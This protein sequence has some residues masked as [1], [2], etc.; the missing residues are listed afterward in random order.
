MAL[1]LG[2]FDDLIPCEEYN[3]IYPEESEFWAWVDSMERDFVNKIN[4]LALE[5]AELDR[6]QN[7]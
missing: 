2:N 4:D 3:A 7:G 6:E 5:A 1:D